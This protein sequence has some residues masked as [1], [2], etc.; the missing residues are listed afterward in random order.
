[1]LYGI[2]ISCPHC[3]ERFE[4][5][6][7]ASEGDADYVEDCPVCCKPIRMHLHPGADGEAPDLDADGDG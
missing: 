7:D 5:L 4:A 2:R 6:A 1:M 3:G